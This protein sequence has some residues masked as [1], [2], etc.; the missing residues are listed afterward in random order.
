LDLNRYDAYEE[1]AKQ[2]AQSR[3]DQAARIQGEIDAIDRELARRE[4][5]QE[6]LRV[7]H[8]A[9]AQA[10][11]AQRR[12]EE[13]RSTRWQAVQEREGQARQL[14]D[15]QAR[16][17]RSERDLA[18]GRNQL[19]AARMQLTQ[20]E[21][22]LAQREEIEAG[23]TELQQVRTDNATWNARLVRH[24]QVS[25][26]LNRVRL[27]VDQA[28]LTLEADRRRL[29][30]RHEE[31]ARKAAFGLE[32]EQ[33]L[34]QLKVLMADLAARE[35]RRQAIALELRGLVEQAGSR[36]ADAERLK[37]DGLAIREKIGLLAE[38]ESAA[39]PLCG[40]ALTLEHRD[41]MLA[42]M[43]SERDRLAAQY[44]AN[45]AELRS[46]GLRKSALEAEDEEAGR[47][48]QAGMHANAR[49]LRPRQP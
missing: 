34:S 11:Q 4:E 30:D 31:L 26:Q 29:S 48:L 41:Q 17:V 35:A 37:A 43:K 22:V 47:A 32:Q 24:I 2:E 23:W 21:A 10:A 46:M 5:Y 8:D 28:R 45:Q 16:V 6:R 39:C 40:Q 19:D 18:D 3:K 38:A 44:Q 13:E 49:W 12:A 42:D 20:Y 15:L 25:E 1:R 36:Q 33:I 14:A 27:A 7:A 9:A